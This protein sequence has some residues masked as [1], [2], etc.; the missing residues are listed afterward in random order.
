MK[1]HEK[2]DTQI[3]VRGAGKGVE[4]VTSLPHRLIMEKVTDLWTDV[5]QPARM[6]YNSLSKIVN[7]SCHSPQRHQYCL[8]ASFGGQNRP[9]KV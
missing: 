9:F 3:C 8:E 5:P 7:R 4:H 1:D 2:R 6:G